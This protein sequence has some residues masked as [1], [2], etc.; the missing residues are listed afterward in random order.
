MIELFYSIKCINCVHSSSVYV[1]V[2]HVQ[3]CVSPTEVY[4]TTGRRLPPATLEQ[5]PLFRRRDL[6]DVRYNLAAL[7]HNSPTNGLLACKMALPAGEQ[8]LCHRNSHTGGR[9]GGLTVFTDTGFTLKLFVNTSF[10]LS[11]SSFDPN[12]CHQSFPLSVSI[13]SSPSPK[14]ASS[15]GFPQRLHFHKSEL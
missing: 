5:R 15:V 9:R 14:S 1:C 7:I 8:S 12:S 10:H 13:L 11:L 3:D 6:R 2:P 4:H